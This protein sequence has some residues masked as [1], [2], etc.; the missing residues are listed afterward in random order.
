[1]WGLISPS[2]EVEDNC[3]RLYEDGT[4]VPSKTTCPSKLHDVPPQRNVTQN[5]RSLRLA[6]LCRHLHSA[7]EKS[8]TNFSYHD[9]LTKCTQ[10]VKIPSNSVFFKITSETRKYYLGHKSVCFSF[11]YKVFFEVASAVMNIERVAYEVHSKPPI[12]LL[13]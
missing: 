6:W 9:N 12:G 5:L 10:S 7:F 13:F 8:V 11:H 1:M 4:A 3:V 2:G